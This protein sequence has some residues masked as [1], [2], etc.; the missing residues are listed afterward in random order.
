MGVYRKTFLDGGLKDVFEWAEFFFR[1][2]FGQGG[3]DDFEVG[4]TDLE[5]REIPFCTSF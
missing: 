3:R 4:E 2:V 5:N 1:E